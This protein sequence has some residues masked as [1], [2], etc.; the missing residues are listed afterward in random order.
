MMKIT[1]TNDLP[2]VAQVI[3]DAFQAAPW[4]M[5]NMSEC[6]IAQRLDMFTP[7]QRTILS[8]ELGEQPEGQAMIGTAWFGVAK[9]GEI[10]CQVSS[11]LE[12]VAPLRTQIYFGA[13]AVRYSFQGMGIARTLKQDALLRIKSMY[14]A[15]VLVT[16]MRS[17]N[18]R[19]IRINKAHGFTPSGIIEI[20]EEGVQDEWWIKCNV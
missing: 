4:H 11:L 13:T 10:P 3:R 2:S 9:A 16:R 17:D 1:K 8:A 14:P 5:T 19:I 7:G 6:K 15:C 20:S 18:D 12:K